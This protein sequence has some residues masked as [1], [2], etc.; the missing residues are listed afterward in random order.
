MCIDASLQT[1]RNPHILCDINYIW[2]HIRCI[3]TPLMHDIYMYMYHIRYILTPLMHDIYHVYIM[4]QWGENIPYMLPNCP[5]CSVSHTHTT[6]RQLGCFLAHRC[7]TN[8][9]PPVTRANEVE[10]YIIHVDTCMSNV[11]I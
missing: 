11:Y 10:C 7:D 2:E 5:T 4:H 8:T 3:L 9:I 6:S 1:L